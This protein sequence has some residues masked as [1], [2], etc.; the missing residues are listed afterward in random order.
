MNVF[1]LALNLVVLTGPSGVR[2]DINP[3]AITS[4]RDPRAMPEGH[5]IKNT[6]CIILVDGGGT[7]AVRETCDEV[8][9]ELPV[10]GGSGPPCV[11]VCG[12]TPTKH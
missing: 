6:H 2:I 12:D 7:I 4:I 5:W 8:R 1:I 11:L 10:K 3:D 9:K